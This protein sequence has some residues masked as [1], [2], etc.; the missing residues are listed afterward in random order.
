MTTAIESSLAVGAPRRVD[1]LTYYEMPRHLIMSVL[2]PE[3]PEVFV[4]EAR[5]YESLENQLER[6]EILREVK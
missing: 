5:L 2:R 3:Y 6:S 4:E 1:N